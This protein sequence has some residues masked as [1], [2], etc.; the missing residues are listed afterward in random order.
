MSFSWK[1]LLPVALLNIFITGAEV[2]IW[3]TWMSGWDKFPWPFL[4]V[5]IPLALA[6]VILWFK[7]FFKLGGG[8]VEVREVR[9]GYCEG[10]AADAEASISA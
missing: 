7:L 9:P 8:R 4:F 2:L 3:Q 1:F 6:I 10:A 5:N